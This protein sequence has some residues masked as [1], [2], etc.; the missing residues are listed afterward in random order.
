VK[1][2]LLWGALCVLMG[3]LAW[4]LVVEPARLV[5]R[6]ETIARSGLPPRRVALI[7]DLHAGA[8]F[9]DREKIHHL[10]DVV[11]AESPDLVLLLGDYL[12]NGRH[13]ARLTLKGGPLEPEDVA[14][15]LGRLRA[16]DGVFAVLGNHDWW[17]D[18]E[19][20]TAA[21]TAAGITVLENEAVRVGD[22][23]DRADGCRP[24]AR[25]AGFAAMGGAPD[26]AVALRAAIRRRA[27]RGGPPAT[28]R[29]HRRGHQHLSDPLRRS[30]RSRDPHLVAPPQRTA[31]P[32]IH[33]SPA[34]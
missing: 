2:R 29:H 7:A 19:R 24:Y 8:R 9:I 25:G 13:G 14:R 4:A 28:V 32:S 10:V 1:R 18:G 17:F 27:R 11:N 20:V 6:R 22:L 15:E 30:A 21:L 3:L 5:V 12:N 34:K 23:W 33:R 16:R 26:R 31:S